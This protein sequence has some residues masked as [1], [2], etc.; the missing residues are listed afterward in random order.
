MY[1][2]IST[3]T[4]LKLLFSNIST[5][6]ENKK[7]KEI[8][9]IIKK[10]DIDKCNLDI[11]TGLLRIT[12]IYRSKLSHWKLLLRKTENYLI[13]NKEDV[14]KELAGLKDKNV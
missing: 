4:E 11:L 12:F 3:I 13:E 5:L 9:N 6:Y 10:I 14:E 7:F 1:N 2:S 8:N